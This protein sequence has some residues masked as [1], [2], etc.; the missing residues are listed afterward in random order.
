VLSLA[1][2]SDILCLCERGQLLYPKEP[3]NSAGFFEPPG[4]RTAQHDNLELVQELLDS[5]AKYFQTSARQEE[6]AACNIVHMPGMQTTAVG[7]VVLIGRNH[8]LSK[9]LESVEQRLEELTCSHA[10]FYQ[11]Y[12][13]ETLESLFLEKG[14]QRAEEIAMLHSLNGDQIDLQLFSKVR[15]QPVKTNADWSQKLRLH[16]ANPSGPDGHEYRA[17]TWVEMEQ[18]KCAAGYMHPFL[19]RNQDE[20]CGAV[21]FAPSKSLGRLKN[22][23]IDQDWRRRGIGVHAAR[24]IAARARELGKRAAGCFATVGGNAVNLYKAA[25]YFPVTRQI[26]W[27]RKLR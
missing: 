15:L 4:N 13:D 12:P 17:E 6:L 3:I 19:V 16:R 18:R 24:L 26:E 20:I 2:Y 11:Q 5:D 14:Y 22:L 1:Q 7:C 8:A 21:N 10:R 23:V 25:G 9:C 27:Y